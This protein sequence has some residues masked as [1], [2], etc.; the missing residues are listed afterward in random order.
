MPSSRS[1]SRKDPPRVALL[2]ETSKSFGRGLLRGIA[3]YLRTHRRWSVFVDERGLR[4]PPPSWL[5][6][7]KGDGIISRG[8]DESVAR[9]AVATGAA[10]VDLGERPLPG[11]GC[12]LS[13]NAAISQHAVDHLLERG[14]E[15]FGFA[16]ITGALWSEDRRAGFIA[17]VAAHRPAAQP[18]T[19]VLPQP[20]EGPWD[21]AEK[22]LA[23]W[24]REI[25]KPAGVMACYDVLGLRVLDACRN[26]G[27]AVPEEVAVVGV[28][29]D[30]VLCDVAD[31]PLSSIAHHV[32]RMGY[33]ASALLDRVMA[34]EALP[35]TPL[36]IP[37]RGV[38]ARQSTDVVAIPDAD[39]AAALH[40]IRSHATGRIGVDDVVRVTRLSRRGLERRFARYLG[41]SPRAEITRQQLERVQQLLGESEFPLD[42]IAR[43][44]G[45]EH[46]A[47]MCVLFREKVGMTPGKYRKQLRYG[48]Q[49]EPGEKRQVQ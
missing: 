12:V 32:E 30:E 18:A 49:G 31:P 4:E 5:A 42:E 25:P 2:I 10:V 33:E 45:F 48:G 37:P 36:S 35:A 44:A 20:G 40:F 26:N 39:V 16:G 47:Y 11:L 34:G 21:D 1:R 46:T 15:H 3:H 22:E 19:I 38:I 23:A 17:A 9:A 41:R 29:N 13:D 14:F 7:W 8:H 24:V 28:D 27:I 43:L 6:T